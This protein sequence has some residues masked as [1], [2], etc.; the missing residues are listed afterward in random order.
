MRRFLN[1]Y[2]RQLQYAARV[3]PTL[4]V[5]FLQVFNL[6]RSPASLLSPAIV[7]RVARRRLRQL[8][9]SRSTPWPAF[10]RT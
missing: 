6:I 4:G 10:L 8:V 5:T 1:W 3:D 2:L 7:W 9:E